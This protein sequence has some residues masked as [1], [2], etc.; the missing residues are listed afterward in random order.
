MIEVLPLHMGRQRA[1]RTRMN[2]PI[3]PRLVTIDM[4]GNA[5]LHSIIP[6]AFREGRYSSGSA[7]HHDSEIYLLSQL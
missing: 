4:K 3:S 1:V 2:T 7:E 5:N 6:C